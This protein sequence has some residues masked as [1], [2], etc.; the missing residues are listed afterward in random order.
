[1]T[2]DNAHAPNYDSRERYVEHAIETAIDRAVLAAE[3][4]RHGMT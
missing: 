4:E 1:M 2:T 3:R